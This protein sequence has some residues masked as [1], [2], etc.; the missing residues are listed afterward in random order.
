MTYSRTR[1]RRKPGMG[2]ARH[3]TIIECLIGGEITQA[4]ESDPSEALRLMRRALPPTRTL[5]AVAPAV[6][7]GR[8]TEAL[9]ADLLDLEIVHDRKEAARRL[10]A[11]YYPIV[12]TDSLELIR[13]VRPQKSRC[14]A[15]II[16][17]C[18]RKL[19]ADRAAGIKAGADECIGSD[20]SE[21]ELHARI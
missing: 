18:D 9:W 4:A 16:Y 12:L 6:A 1:G 14:S 20:A 17:L 15:V 3:A 7:R 10:A 11:A 13:S 8:L 21:E 19:S 2:R 5:M